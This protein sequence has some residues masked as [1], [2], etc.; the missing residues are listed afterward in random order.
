MRALPIITLVLLAG[1]APLGLDAPGSRTFNAPIA[2]V[3]PA[4]ISTLA[5]MGMR[6]SSLE[7]R[8]TRE[9]LRAKKTGSEVEIELED[10]NRISTRARISARGGSLANDPATADRIYRQTEKLLGG[11]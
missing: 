6:I 7:L 2:R 3:K 11:V 8:G 10:V 9:I 5:K 4:V 1:C